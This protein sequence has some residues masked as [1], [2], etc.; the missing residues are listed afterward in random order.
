MPQCSPTK[1]AR[2]RRTGA[3]PDH[4]DRRAGHLFPS[5]CTILVASKDGRLDPIITAVTNASP[6][7]ILRHQEA[8]ALVVDVGKAVN[9]VLVVLRLADQRTVPAMEPAILHFPPQLPA[10]VSGPVIS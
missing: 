1:E 2:G 10:I 6:A 3:D 5:G 9:R 8:G 7:E 4:V